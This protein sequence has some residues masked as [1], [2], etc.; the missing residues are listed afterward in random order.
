MSHT[1]T[2]TFT[3]LVTY[4]PNE[5]A[6]DGGSITYA[7]KTFYV[8]DLTAD[9]PSGTAKASYTT[10]N[11]DSGPAYVFPYNENTQT[12]DAALAAA[13]ALTFPGNTAAI[14]YV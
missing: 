12:V 3:N 8:N 2:V 11:G 6:P 4:K 1:L 14:T 13:L 9:V 7:T 5:V 10:G